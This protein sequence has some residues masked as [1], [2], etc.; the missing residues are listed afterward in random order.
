MPIRTDPVCGRR[1]DPN[2]AW[3][4]GHVAQHRNRTY[5]FCSQ[6]CIRE[7]VW[8]HHAY[9]IATDVVCGHDVEIEE[10]EAAGLHRDFDGSRYYFCSRECQHQ[11]VQDPRFY[12]DLQQRAE[13]M[14]GPEGLRPPA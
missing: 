13:E 3:E 12:R 14:F 11:F 5:Y 2:A 9:A 10:A 6:A 4:T 7:F 8:N 1:V